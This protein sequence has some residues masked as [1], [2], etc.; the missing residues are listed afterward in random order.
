MDLFRNLYILDLVDSTMDIVNFIS[1]AA[2]RGVYHCDLVVWH[3]FL[4]TYFS[5]CLR[6]FEKLNTDR[7]MNKSAIEV[8]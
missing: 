5:M 2:K 1:G 7:K 8:T 6:I 4:L 3:A